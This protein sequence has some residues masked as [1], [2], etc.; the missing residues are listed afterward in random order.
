MIELYNFLFVRA[1]IHLC[2]LC[3]DNFNILDNVQ[4]LEC[5]ETFWQKHV[6]RN[7][8]FKGGKKPI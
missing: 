7:I 4:A 3:V 2:T 6:F 8:D 5:K 1:V